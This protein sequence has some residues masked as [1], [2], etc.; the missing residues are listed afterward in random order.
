[1]ASSSDDSNHMPDAY[2]NE[3]REPPAM[4]ATYRDLTLA[5]FPSRSRSQKT[6][7]ASLRVH[8][9]RLLCCPKETNRPDYR[10]NPLR[11]SPRSG[12]SK[13]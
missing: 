13:T 6:S 10:F 12:S 2:N 1:M 3:G 11:Y 9:E 4:Y 5:D 7:F 8:C